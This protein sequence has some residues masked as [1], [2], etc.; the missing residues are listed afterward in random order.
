MNENLEKKRILCEKAEALK[1]STDW[2]TT[3]EELTKLQKEWKT[4]GPVAKKYSD[5]IWKRF[6]SACDYFFEQ[7]NKATSSQRSVEQENLEK[8]KVIIEKLT[9]IDET[10][11][12]EEATLLVRELMKEWN[13]V[14]HVPF[15]EKD[16]IY[17]QYHGQ[18][19]KLFERFNIRAE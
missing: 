19:D 6:I 9:A 18:I 4:V 5:A 7:K 17:K 14:G 1:D 13:S 8:K 2:K 16:K 15:K 10:M 12:V 11:D 3:A